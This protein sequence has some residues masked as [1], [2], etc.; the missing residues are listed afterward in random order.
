MPPFITLLTDYGVADEFVGV[1]HGVIAGICPDARVIDLTHGIA[2]HEVRPGAIVLRNALAHLP[3]GVHVAVV[4]PGVGGERRAVALALADE[5]ILVGPDNGLLGPAAQ[6]GGG[7]VQAVDASRSPFRLA[8]V[9]ATFHGRDVFAP[10]AA[11]LAAGAALAEAGEPLDPAELVA[12]ELP[13]PR[14]DGASLVAHALLVDRFGN[15]TLDAEHAELPGSGLRLGQAVELEIGGA[16]RPARYA[17][18]F[19]DVAPGE[20]LLYEDAHGALA[21]AVNRGSAAEALAIEL[22]DEVGIRP[23]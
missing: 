5:R 12:L 3:V 15:V 22:D 11:H 19:V 10:I 4:D 14:R 18:A 17:Q 16:R 1:C 6:R 23:A 20:T 2:R 21:L 7:V 13:R 9:S 8:P